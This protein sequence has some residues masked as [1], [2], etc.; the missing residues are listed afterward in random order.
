MFNWKQ[1]QIT[2]SI[3]SQHQSYQDLIGQHHITIR[4]VDLLRWVELANEDLGFFTLVDIAGVDLKN[5]YK[6][7]YQFELTY[8]LLNMGTHQRLNIHV[9]FDENEIVPSIV[10]LYPHADWQEREQKEALGI[11][12]DRPM[13]SLLLPKS[14]TI[15]PLRKNANLE[16]WPLN[17][18]DQLPV[19]RTNPNKSEAPYPEEAHEW[20]SYSLYSPI[21]SGLFES[22]VCFDPQDVVDFKVDIGHNHQGLEK[23]LEKKDWQQVLQL[24]DKIHLG[25]APTYGIAWAKNLEDVLRVK[26]PERAQAIRIVALELARIAE[27]L[28]VMHEIAFSLKLDEYKLIIN[29]R[30]KLYELMEKFCG[31][32][33]G[34]SVARLGGIKEDLPHGWITQYQS[35]SAIVMKALRLIH[36]SLCSQSKFRDRL[37]GGMVSAQSALQWGISGPAMRAS[38]LNFDLRKSQ[39]FY[40]YQDIDFDIP[41][42]INGTAFERYLIRYEEIFQSFRIITQVIDNLPLG[43][44]MNADYDLDFM[45]VKEMLENIDFPKVWHYTGLESP[46]GEAGFL[47]KFNDSFSPYRLKIK[48]PSLPL[49]QALGHLVEGIHA[50]DL[51]ANLASIGL[52]HYELDR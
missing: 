16:S 50:E 22:M 9:E 30:E 6:N 33:Q 47:V 45:A 14:Q 12:F 11:L 36:H 25:A 5:V 31:R 37:S 29:A 52:R 40:F 19:I 42:G 10:S 15:Y 23:L 32:R 51:Q 38:G 35:A 28:T 13:D 1:F 49:A 39:P 48:T 26:L 46:N 41:V 18:P 21:S 4:P 44:I 24:V 20:K 27:H 17:V 7:R 43:D 8:H 2:K 3:F 34:L